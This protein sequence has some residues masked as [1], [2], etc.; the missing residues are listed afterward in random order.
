MKETE[1]LFGISKTVEEIESYLGSSLPSIRKRLNAF[2]EAFNQEFRNPFEKGS[3]DAITWA[4]MQYPLILYALKMNGLAAVELHSILERFAMRD[5]IK[6]LA[7]PK[8]NYVLG[9]L[10]EK[11]GL[12]E[13]ALAYLDLGAW[14]KDDIKLVNK[15][16]KIRNGVAH[17]N[18]KIISKAAGSGKEI[19]ILDIDFTM[20]K[21]DVVPLIIGTIRLLMKLSAHTR[22]V[23]LSKSKNSSK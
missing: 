11:V 19:H 9:K 10:I 2:S 12:S 4:L 17:K 7:K 14:D 5:L 1:D 6:H 15:L 18:P 20:T 16:S 3:A 21:F 23:K 8:H 22:K 13:L